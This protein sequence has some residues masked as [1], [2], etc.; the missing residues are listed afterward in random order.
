MRPGTPD[1]AFIYGWIELKDVDKWP[2]HDYTPLRIRH[3][4]PQQRVWIARHAKRGGNVW[5]LLR[6][7]SDWLLFEGTVA[8]THLGYR[9]QKELRALAARTWNKRL[10]E[11]EL[12]ALVSRRKKGSDFDDE[13]AD[14]RRGSRDRISQTLV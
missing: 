8:A 5:V 6:I 13:Y 9:T 4:T 7:N 12:I 11:E 3:F 10:N 1:I 14:R 2:V